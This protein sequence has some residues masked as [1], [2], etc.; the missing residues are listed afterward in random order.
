MKKP[1]ASSVTW[2]T[3]PRLDQHD[4]RALLDRK[5]CEELHL[6]RE[7][8]SALAICRWSVLSSSLTIT[9]T[10]DT[11][12]ALIE[13]RAIPSLSH[14]ETLAALKTKQSTSQE[15]PC[16]KPDLSTPETN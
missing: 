7:L 1:E 9:G 14:R 16:P 4:T 8:H 11:T 13:I 10:G 15:A 6:T 5:Q 12:E 3:P 2:T